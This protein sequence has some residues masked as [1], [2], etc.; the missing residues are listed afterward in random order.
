MTGGGKVH[1]DLTSRSQ[2]ALRMHCVLIERRNF[3][4]YGNTTIF[5]VLRKRH[6]LHILQTT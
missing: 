5:A 2:G 6:T 3:I 4:L 1:L